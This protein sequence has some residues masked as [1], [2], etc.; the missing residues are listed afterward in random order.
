MSTVLPRRV[1]SQTKYSRVRRR[2]GARL[3][4]E[5]RKKHT[6]HMRRQCRPSL[7]N[8]ENRCLLDAGWFDAP[9]RGFGTGYFPNAMGPNS[10]AVGDLD[11]DGDPEVVLGN[12][13]FGAPGLSVLKNLGDGTYGAPQIIKLPINKSV[14][15]VELADFDHDGDLD[16]VASV[17]DPNGLTNEIRLF[18]NIGNGMLARRGVTF[19]AGPGP[20]GIVIRDFSGDGFP[21]V[22]TADY[23]YI[24]GSNATISLLKHNGQSGPAAGFLAPVSFNAGNHPTRVAAGDVNGDGWLDVVVGR[25]GLGGLQFGTLSVMLN[26]QGGGFTAPVDYPALPGASLYSPAVALADLDL[27]GDLDLIGAGGL[28]APSTSVVSVR[29][30]AGN[31]SFGAAETYKL[32]NWSE[33]PQHVAAGDLNGD[34]F[35]DIIACANQASVTDGWNVLLSNGTGGFLPSVRYEASASTAATAAIDADG[36]GDLDVITVAWSAAVVTVHKNQGDG[37]FSVLPRYSAGFFIDGFD[38]ADIDLDGDRDVVTSD[39]KVHVLRNNGNGTFAPAQDFTLSVDPNGAWLRDVNND[40]FP[41]LLT[42]YSV[43]GYQFARALNKGDG[44]FGPVQ[45]TILNSCGFGT[46]GAFD[47]DNDGDL[48]VAQ[49]EEA[50]GPGCPPRRIF[51]LR[52]DGSGSFNLDFVIQSALPNGIAGGDLNHD[53]NVDLVSGYPGET[54]FFPGNGDLTF[55]PRIGSGS[56]PATFTAADMNNDGEL[57]L[58]MIMGPLDFYVQKIGIS[59]GNG[60]GT[61]APAWTIPGETSLTIGPGVDIDA[62]DMNV[63]G[64]VDILVTNRGSNDV[65]LFLGTGNGTLKPQDRYGVGARASH[66]A[67]ADFTGDGIADVVSDIALPP[68]GG[69]QAI[70]LL[71]GLSGSPL[72]APAPREPMDG[73][74]IRRTETPKRRDHSGSLRA[75]LVRPITSDQLEQPIRF[76]PNPDSRLVHQRRAQIEELRWL[77][78]SVAII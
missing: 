69:A 11:A 73:I 38:S 2:S 10:L 8:L 24:A 44:T 48:D 61:F 15:D 50:T 56:Y 52:N 35:P 54:S 42:Q 36:D 3:H 53:G 66:S 76:Q 67:F 43:G 21:D 5:Y 40:G 74:E 12:Y 7:E 19:G 34:G 31:G 57:D 51:I 71:R 64:F 39:T 77:E 33:R 62:T 23:G 37:L 29:R 45:V 41:D 75:L 13:H 78:S 28:S 46:V 1:P 4:I 49:T 72:P 70:V 58:A 14:G 17:P 32:E 20:I 65:S 16:A 26:N 68:A 47:L 27:D 60:D 55:A 59:L 6:E 18:R 63:N 30:N 25:S 22:V 9:W